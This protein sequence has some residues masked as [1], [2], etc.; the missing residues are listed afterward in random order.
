LKDFR[1]LGGHAA[2]ITEDLGES[3]PQRG[4]ASAGRSVVPGPVAKRFV[5]FVPEPPVQL[6]PGAELFVVDVDPRDPTT[7]KPRLA[8]AARQAVCS[9]D[10]AKVGQLQWGL[11]ALGHVRQHRDDDL[12]VPHTGPVGCR[13]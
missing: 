8:V 12:P 1:L 6:D 7:S 5:D 11:S 10:P 3:V 2:R 13:H 9:L 4:H